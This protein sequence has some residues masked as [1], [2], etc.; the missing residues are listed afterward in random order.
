LPELGDSGSLIITS[1]GK[2]VAIILGA[3]QITQVRLIMDEKGII[4]IQYTQ[5]HRDENGNAQIEDGW[6]YRLSDRD[7]VIVESLPM[8]LSKAGLEGN[9][10]IINM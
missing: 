3:Y 1:E 6:T 8:I 7:I 4:D 5:D 10:V 9:E 2:G